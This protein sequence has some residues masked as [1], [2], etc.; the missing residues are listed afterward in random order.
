L[1]YD[2][3]INTLNIAIPN[4]TLFIAGC[5][6]SGTTA[7]TRL[8]NSH[9]DIFIGTELFRSEFTKKTDEF[10]KDLFGTT[11]YQSKLAEV[12]ESPTTLQHVGDKFPSYYSDYDLLFDRFDQVK[13]L[14]IFRNIFDVAQS[15]KARK[16]HPTNPW[17]KGV[18]RAVK[19]WNSS[20]ELS[21]QHIKSGKNIIPLCY[22]NVL[23]K[24]DQNLKRILNLPQSKQ[25]NMYYKKSTRNAAKI[26]SQR[27]NILDNK[28]KL[29]IMRQAR[30]DLYNEM[31]DLSIMQGK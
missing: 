16:I 20:L 8:L 13:V 5:A 25:Y 9:E 3:N 29:V 31:Y 1:N 2:T 17:N 10:N 27:T 21:L 15:Y 12:K 14:F 24:P 23:F 4:Q 11:R 6:R 28:E 26:E 7:L 18:K 19:E 30:F 22:E